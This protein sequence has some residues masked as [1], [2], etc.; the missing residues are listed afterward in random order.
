MRAVV[1]PHVAGAVG[2]LEE[3][4]SGRPVVTHGDVAG[5]LVRIEVEPMVGVVDVGGAGNVAHY[6][7]ANQ[8][9]GLITKGI[10]AG[11]VVHMLGIVVDEVR[12]HA[13]VLHAHLVAVPTPPQ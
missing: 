3:F 6:I 11:A 1:F 8:R 13:V 4:S 12:M 2:I 7:L 9:T 5:A 10:D